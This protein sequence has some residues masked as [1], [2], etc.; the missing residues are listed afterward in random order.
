MVRC[1]TPWVPHAYK[2]ALEGIVVQVRD[3]FTDPW[4]APFDA[5]DDRHV[6][7]ND[8]TMPRTWN[9]GVDFN[10]ATLPAGAADQHWQVVGGPGIGAPQLAVVVADQHPG[11]AYFPTTDSMWIWQDVAGSGLA[12]TYTYQLTIDL[13]GLDPSTV[14]LAGA[15]GVDNDGTITLNGSP[16]VGTGTFTLTNAAHD[17][18]NVVHPFAITG[19]FKAGTNT[20]DVEVSNI[21]GPGALNVTQLTMSGT[22]A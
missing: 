21:D 19:G 11:G 12:T 1:P 15:W 4:T 2:A 6:G 22:P 18:Y 3:L 13:S 16:P 17:N 9:T 10:A 14:T 7:R 8:D 5:I 20:L